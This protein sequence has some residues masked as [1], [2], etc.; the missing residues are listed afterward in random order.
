MFCNCSSV[1]LSKQKVFHMHVQM[2]FHCKLT[3]PI[4]WW[5]I[6]SSLTIYKCVFVWVCVCA[7]S[8][9]SDSQKQQPQHIISTTNFCYFY[10]TPTTTTT[11][12]RRT[13]LQLLQLLLLL[14]LALFHLSSASV[15]P[16]CANKK[17]KNSYSRRLIRF[18]FFGVTL[19]LFF[20]CPSALSISCVFAL[21]SVSWCRAL[22]L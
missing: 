18:F 5:A 9:V 13:R 19:L 3:T 11:T 16:Y 22:E 10:Y 7:C 21:V 2:L 20:V 12:K 4:H 15:L 6:W 14:F 17:I 1:H 8:S